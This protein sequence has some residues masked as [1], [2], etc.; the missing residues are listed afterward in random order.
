MILK[1]KIGLGHEPSW[2][3][4]VIYLSDYVFAK[5][6]SNEE[7]SKVDPLKHL[8]LI[9]NPVYVNYQK[10]NPLISIKVIQGAFHCSEC[11]GLHYEVD[12]IEIPLYSESFKSLHSFSL[13]L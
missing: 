10:K 11:T 6:L 5:D 3:K 1:N 9:R 12:I 4:E 13:F 7:I 8:K 2:P